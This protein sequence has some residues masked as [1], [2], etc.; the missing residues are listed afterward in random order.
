LKKEDPE[1]ESR[2]VNS[3]IAWAPATLS[4]LGPGFDCL[5][6]AISEWGDEVKASFNNTKTLRIFDHKKSAWMG[7]RN[8]DSNTA[9][10]AAKK[11]LHQLGS[12]RGV[13]LIIRKG[14]VPGSG[15]GSSAA[16]AAAAAW[17]VNL[18]FGEPLSKA[19]LVDA[20]L[21]GE[22]VASGSLHGDNVLASLFGG[23]VLSSPENPSH[24]RCMEVKSGLCFSVIL[25]DLEILTR[26]AREL[27]PTQVT[28]GD[29][30]ANAS[31]LG[32]LVNA[33]REGDWKEMGQRIMSDR[34]VEPVRQTRLPC[35]EA[36]RRAALKAGA[37]GCALS[38]SGPCM[39][40]ITGSNQLADT[41]LQAM[42]QAATMN[43]ID[44]TGITTTI[45]LIGARR[46]SVPEGP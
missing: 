25:P 40:A 39:F 45:D 31:S 29:A 11:V 22:S 7:P 20:V 5:G 38:G 36:V 12:A 14:I 3:A 32:F 46:I 16:S 34:I 15:A 42:I 26:E 17:A 37:F 10:T 35:F 41:V 18:L 6:L 9:G 19:N 1:S 2:S 30:I 13:D 27:L 44:S 33:M 24:F 21:V 43:N 4:N 28:F 23:I 8:P